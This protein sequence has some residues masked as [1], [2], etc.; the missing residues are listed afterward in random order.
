MKRKTIISFQE[1]KM[2]VC[3][4]VCLLEILEFSLNV[5]IYVFEL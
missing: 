5:C 4:L 3:V 1:N 2:C